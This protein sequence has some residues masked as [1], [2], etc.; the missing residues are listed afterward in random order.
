MTGTLNTEVTASVYLLNEGAK[1][2]A[3]G[4][5][6][7]TVNGTYDYA[8]YHRM[9]LAN[10]ISLPKG[11]I[12]GIVILQRVHTPEG[13]RYVFVNTSSLGQ[14]SI[15]KYAEA[16]EDTEDKPKRYCTGIVNPGENFVSFE[17]GRWIGTGLLIQNFYLKHYRVIN[18]I[19][20]LTLG[21][22]IW[23]M[24]K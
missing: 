12:I 13:T 24:L 14:K 23:S 10:N 1:G 2:P 11:S 5:L 7:E 15:E 8:G 22:C 3:D 18:I 21:E 6:M 16:G 19:L 20:A 9:S 4:V 17:D